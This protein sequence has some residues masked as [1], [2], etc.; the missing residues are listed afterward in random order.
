MD[1]REKLKAEMKKSDII[2]ELSHIRIY[3]GPENY[4]DSIEMDDIDGNFFD[5]DGYRYEIVELTPEQENEVNE[6]GGYEEWSYEKNSIHL[7]FYF[8][9]FGEPLEGDN[10]SIIFT[11]KE[12]SL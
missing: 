12:I 8:K 11:V 3:G 1:L 7:E 9:E 6:C 4:D 2:A 5:Y 10:F